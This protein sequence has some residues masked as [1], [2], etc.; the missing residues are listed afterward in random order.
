MADLPSF[1]GGG[2]WS[3]Q[4][5]S[6]DLT[7]KN[8]PFTAQGLCGEQGGSLSVL[9]YSAGSHCPS[10]AALVVHLG[11]RPQFPGLHRVTRPSTAM[12][13]LH[14]PGRVVCSGHP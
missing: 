10:C 6:S 4:G 11:L 8:L 1:F 9:R 12:L 3:C 2:A 14:L 7:F 13:M 5:P